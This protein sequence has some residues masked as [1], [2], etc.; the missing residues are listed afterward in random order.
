MSSKNTLFSYFKKVDKPATPG[1][2][3]AAAEKKN[4]KASSEQD[5]AKNDENEKPKDSVSPPNKRTPKHAP[6]KESAK[7]KRKVDEEKSAREKG[8]K[9]KRIVTNGTHSITCSEVFIIKTNLY[10]LV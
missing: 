8:K 10:R 6:S 1:R 4:E 7:K 5:K 3:P 2:E 9:F